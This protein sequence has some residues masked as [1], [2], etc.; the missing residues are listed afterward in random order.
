MCVSESTNKH[1]QTGLSMRMSRLRSRSTGRRLNNNN[2][3]KLTKLKN[4]HLS[5][6]RGHNSSF[7]GSTF[8]MFHLAGARER[9]TRL[10]RPADRGELN[11]HDILLGDG[12]GWDGMNQLF[13][14]A[15]RR[16]YLLSHTYFW[17]DAKMGW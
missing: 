4:L 1:K 8:F 9:P 16:P 11:L 15:K 2:N 5:D 14:S 17:E 7:S 6:P 12:I 3:N 10:H 13:S